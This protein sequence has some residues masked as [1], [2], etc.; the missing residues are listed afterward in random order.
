MGKDRLAAFSE[1]STCVP[2]ELVSESLGVVPDDPAEPR[3]EMTV[4]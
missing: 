3:D 2:L 4:I 1:L